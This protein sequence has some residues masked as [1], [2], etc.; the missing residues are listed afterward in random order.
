[1]RI[2]KR[3]KSLGGKCQG[4]R[5]AMSS[6]DPV[7]KLSDGKARRWSNATDGGPG[8]WVCEV[9]ALAAIGQLGLFTEG[10]V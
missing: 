5:R 2:L 1:M 6:G 9:C 10:A 7:F 4:C 8:S 3:S